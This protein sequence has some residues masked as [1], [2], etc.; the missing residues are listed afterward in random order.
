MKSLYL[1]ALTLLT[2]AMLYVQHRYTDSENAFA[3]PLRKLGLCAMATAAF[4]IL[5]LTVPPHWLSVL[6]QGC[7]FACVDLL[8]VWLYRF[9][10]KYTGTRDFLAD[11]HVLRI[12]LT[13]LYIA[14]GASMLL[15]VLFMHAFSSRDVALGRGEIVRVFD[16]AGPLFSFHLLLCYITVTLSLG[17]VLYKMV[18]TPKVFRRKF[19]LLLPLLCAIFALDILYIIF[20]PSLDV[21]L[22]FYV[23]MVLAL[24]YLTYVYAPQNILSQTAKLVMQDMADGVICFDTDGQCV[25]TNKQLYN[26]L[27]VPGS[28]NA[29]CKLFLYWKETA[30]DKDSDAPYYRYRLPGARAERYYTVKRQTLTDAKNVPIGTCYTVYNRTDDVLALRRETYRASHDSLTDLHN[31]DYFFKA[32]AD[33]LNQDQRTTYLMLA[34]DFKDFKLVN[35]FFGVEKGNELLQSFAKILRGYAEAGAIC[36]RLEDDHFAMCIRKK[37]FE[38][39]GFLAQVRELSK[40]IAS[41]TFRLQVYTGL[42][43]ITNRS[44]SVPNMCDR[45]HMAIN[46]IKG[47]YTAQIASYTDEM[48]Q[49]VVYENALLSEFDDAL[50]NHQFRLYLQPQ[51]D[52]KGVV[53][54]AEALVRWAHPERGIIPP[55]VFIELFERT[56]VIY[57]LDHYMWEQACERLAIWRDRGI[58]D[59]YISVN[60]S[61]RDFYYM[62]IYEVLTGL[63]EQYDLSPTALHLEITET[64]LMQDSDKTLTIIKH[65]QNYGFHIEIDDFGS[66]YSS[67]NMLKDINADLLKIDRMFLKKTEDEARSRTILSIVIELARRLGMAVLT[68]G[69]ETYEQLQYLSAEGC[70]YFQGYY[71]AKPM[72]VAEF[73]SNYFPTPVR[74]S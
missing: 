74:L 46:S 3:R 73:E 23:A 26:L 47:D 58:V 41:K 20:Q 19:S 36:C 32:V 51:T 4:N 21:S 67:L 37:D 27:G 63:I 8:L 38:P 9:V 48:M 72:P 13:L 62:D 39:E 17:T 6:M 5:A 56:G 65:L 61:T 11:R 29:A 70:D 43:E 64:A 57:R 42:Y 16:P 45:A 14:D 28:R 30:L 2:I 25:Y 50:R 12:A 71:F 49:I 54:G 53:Q 24:Y 66:G 22:F 44:L 59:F 33:L 40:H 69:V 52:K 1:C 15:N 31:R 18:R 10:L 55:A 60:I 35:E 34:T 68:E 7:H